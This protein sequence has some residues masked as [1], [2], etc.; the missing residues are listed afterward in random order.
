[1][2]KVVVL[3]RDAILPKDEAPV[4]KPVHVTIDPL[5]NVSTRIK[6]KLEYGKE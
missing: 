6:G 3:L 5:D 1:M 2:G 4:I